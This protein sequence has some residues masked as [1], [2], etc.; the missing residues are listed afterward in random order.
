MKR[1][2]FIQTSAAIPSFFTLGHLQ[3]QVYQQ[4]QISGTENKIYDF[5]V[6]GMRSMGSATSF[7]LTKCGY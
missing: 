6:L 2:K 7:Y 4:L 5:I 1:R 3:K